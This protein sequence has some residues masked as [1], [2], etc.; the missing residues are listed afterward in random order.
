MNKLHHE[1]VA[2]INQGIE[3]RLSSYTKKIEEQRRRFLR[4]MIQRQVFLRSE[5][6]RL[7]DEK[8]KNLREKNLIK[9]HDI[10]E[11]IKFIFQAGF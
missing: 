6:K 3:S 8:F 11:H 10:G 1:R 5:Y 9:Y 7:K 2:R 4:N